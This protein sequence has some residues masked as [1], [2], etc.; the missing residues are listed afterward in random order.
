MRIPWRSHHLHHQ[1]R[2]SL[3]NETLTV[4]VK[5]NHVGLLV[6]VVNHPESS[7]AILVV[8]SVSCATAG[9][10]KY[11]FYSFPV[12]WISQISMP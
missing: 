8:I 6:L 5:H 10:F 4:D 3:L 9:N 12:Y 7:E 11:L 2:L 1:L